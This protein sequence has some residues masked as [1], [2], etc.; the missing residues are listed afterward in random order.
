MVPAARRLAGAET[1]VLIPVPLSAARRRE[2]GFNQAELLAQELAIRTGWPLETPL[3]R[4]SGGR[5]FAGLGRLER[6]ARAADAFVATPESLR[7]EAQ[8][9]RA[10]LVDD[11]IT[12]GATA[13]A[14]AAA[15]ETAGI[16]CI[17]AVSF[18]RTGR[19]LVRS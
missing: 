10:L 8:G 6:A 12:T 2:R 1:P 3:V 14:C 18:A 4:R 11:V 13:G 15:L 9:Q 16:R 7:G 17:G 5:A 19:S